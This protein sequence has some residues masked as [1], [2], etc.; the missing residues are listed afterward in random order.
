M[1]ESQILT[2]IKLWAAV[3]WADE[4]LAE[5]EAAGLRKLIAAAELTADERTA[6]M[7]LLDRKVALADTPLHS[8]APDA[9]RGIYRAACR[10]AIVDHVLAASERAMLD[11]LRGVLAIP[12]DIASEIE[13][14][15]PGIGA[16]SP[17]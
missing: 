8:L 3:A 1:A 5:P 13:A 12:S 9:R 11:R 10:M 4:V 6:A 7:A 16:P 2:V 14:D 17:A 15:V